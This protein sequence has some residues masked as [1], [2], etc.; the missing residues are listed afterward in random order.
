MVECINI[1]LNPEEIERGYL[2]D[3][4]A[5][6]DLRCRKIKK[7]KMFSVYKEDDTKKRRMNFFI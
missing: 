2:S 6:K 1:K 4:F 5:E 3:Q 7:K